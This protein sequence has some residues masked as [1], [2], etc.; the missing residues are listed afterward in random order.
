MKAATSPA[1]EPD[2]VRPASPVNT[3]VPAAIPTFVMRAASTN[4]P[5]GASRIARMAPLVSARRYSI[6]EPQ[7][8]A[9]R[10]G[11]D[12]ARPS[13]GGSLPSRRSAGRWT[14]DAPR[15]C[16]AARGRCRRRDAGHR[17]RTAV[18]AAIATPIVKRCGRSAA[19]HPA[20]GG[21]RR[22]RSIACRT[23]STTRSTAVRGSQLRPTP[24]TRA[25]SAAATAICSNRSGLTCRSGATR[26]AMREGGVGGVKE[27]TIR[28]G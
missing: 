12:S 16:R 18:A 10:R 23:A 4:M 28:V 8:A 17:T 24:P 15:R 26:V 9:S 2:S 7:P 22:P 13:R 6:S 1:A 27:R 20:A 25:T 11:P 3:T 5:I 19:R 14:R 21:R